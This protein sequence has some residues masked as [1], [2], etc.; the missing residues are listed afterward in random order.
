MDQGVPWVGNAFMLLG[1]YW[2]GQLVG[3]LLAMLFMPVAEKFPGRKAK[4]PQ[5]CWCEVLLCPSAY[6]LLLQES[7]SK[8]VSH[9]AQWSQVCQ[10]SYKCVLTHLQMTTLLCGVKGLDTRVWEGSM[11]RIVCGT[12]EKAGTVNVLQL[13]IY[14]P[15]LVWLI[16]KPG[17][18][19]H[20]WT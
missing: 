11:P 6:G 12:Q 14:F 16:L 5:R 2:S 1:L 19:Q 15:C 8:P 17:W 13:H 4:G 9:G 20:K 10:D 3:F 18:I 7:G